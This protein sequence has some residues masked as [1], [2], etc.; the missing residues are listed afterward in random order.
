[1]KRNAFGALLVAGGLAL[2]TSVASFANDTTPT[3]TPDAA[4]ALCAAKLTLTDPASLTGEAKDAVTE[5]NV[6]TSAG[7]SEIVSEASSAIAELKA[8]TD[9]EDGNN[10]VALAARVT[11][12]ETAACT[13]IDNLIAEYT[14][15]VNEIKAESTQPNVDKPEVDKPEVDKA[16]K[17]EVEKAN[18]P[19]VRSTSREGND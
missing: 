5:L 17:P 12:I 4:I 7:L 6:E 9:E 11:A 19:D 15:A 8:N 10:P 3:A 18:K 16:E 13:A 2:W 14:A 1:M